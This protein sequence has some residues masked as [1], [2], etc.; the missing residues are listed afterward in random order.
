MHVLILRQNVSLSS[1][2][3]GKTSLWGGWKSL[4]IR[5]CGH[6][7]YS[8]LCPQAWSRKVAN[9]KTLAWSLA[10]L[11]ICRSNLNSQINVDLIQ[12]LREKLAYLKPPDSVQRP[13]VSR[14]GLK[15]FL[16]IFRNS[17]DVFHNRLQQMSLVTTPYVKH[18][19]LTKG[20]NKYCSLYDN[21]S[22]NCGPL[23]LG[24]NARKHTA[25]QIKTTFLH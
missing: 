17:S 12:Q 14:Y 20:A 22:E 5:T 1:L 24:G 10:P 6:L 7:G 13:R 8:A 25:N 4:A 9:Y 16:C 2:T 11:L 18:H 21:T 19:K 15:T 3:V 23:R